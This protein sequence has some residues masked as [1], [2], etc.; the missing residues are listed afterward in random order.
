M[1]TESMDPI[2]VMHQS[3]VYTVFLYHDLRPAVRYEEGTH[4]ITHWKL[5]LPIFPATNCYNYEK[6]A[7]NLLANLKADF[8]LHIADI[9]THN[10]TVNTEGGVGCGKP[11]HT[12]ICK[13]RYCKLGYTKITQVLRAHVMFL[14]GS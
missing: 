8:P 13:F 4:I 9:V 5:W 1:P 2:Y 7:V 11:S 3:F 14:S 6:E 12:I 10:R